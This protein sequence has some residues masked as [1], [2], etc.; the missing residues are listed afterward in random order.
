MK[1]LHAEIGTRWAQKPVTSKIIYI[2]PFKGLK[3]A[4][5][6]ILF[7]AIYRG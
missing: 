4:K 3:Y 5:L 1:G 2:F 6:A 7:S